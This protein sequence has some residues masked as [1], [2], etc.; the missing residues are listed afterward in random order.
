MLGSMNH[1]L[2]LSEYKQQALNITTRQ[3]AY[4]GKNSTSSGHVQ[5]ALN[6]TIGQ[7]AYIGKKQ[8]NT[9]YCSWHSLHQDHP[10]TDLLATHP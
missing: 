9:V 2:V 10:S 4:I 6:I 1:T 8:H 3:A 5:Q 7:A